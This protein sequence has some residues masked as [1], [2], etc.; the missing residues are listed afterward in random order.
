[1][2]VVA[3]AI[4]CACLGGIAAG[5]LLLAL[6]PFFAVPLLHIGEAAGESIAAAGLTRVGLLGTAYTMEQE[7]YRERLGRSFGLEVLI[8]EQSERETVHQVIFD[9]LCM[10]QTLEGS[11]QMYRE[12]IQGLVDRGAEGIILGCTEIMLLISQDDSP[13]PL[14]DT[15]AIH[16]EAAL[17]LALRS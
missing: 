15:T 16:V 8:P 7:F 1:M 17:E 14:F 6:A 10:G 13:V 5:T 9:E 12:I 3:V 4:V 2:K 11:R